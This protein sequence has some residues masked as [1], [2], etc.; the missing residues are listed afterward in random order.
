MVATFGFAF[1]WVMAHNYSFQLERFHFSGMVNLQEIQS[2]NVMGDAVG[3]A[4]AGSML[5]GLVV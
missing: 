2:R 3:D 5:F 4:F 1:P